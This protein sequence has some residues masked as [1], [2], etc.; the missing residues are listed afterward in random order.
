VKRPATGLTLGLVIAWAL[1]GCGRKHVP[2]ETVPELGYPE[3]P[4]ADR[5]EASMASGHLRAGPYSPEPGVTERFDLLRTACGYVLRSRQEWSLDA[6]DIEV[7]YDSELIPVWAWKRMTV[8]GTKREFA[9]VRRYEL[10]TGPVFITHRSPEGALTHERLLEG[11]RVRSVPGQA[12]G[13]VIGPGRGVLTPW[14]RRA[15][16]AVGQKTKALVLDFRSLVE[17]VEWVTL[18]R[19]EDDIRRDL[20]RRVR[21][22]TF[23]GKETVF[24]DDDDVVIGDLAGMRPSMSL[25]APEPPPLPTY[26][27]A[28]PRRSP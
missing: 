9:D 20:G 19:N 2:V 11:G 25:R 15:H 3:C 17:T 22:Y 23:G 7:R 12:V 24:A 6:S 26:G 16:L 21:V 14:L 4:G 28:D 27:E 10:R 8:P 13:A 18:E 5:S 1:V